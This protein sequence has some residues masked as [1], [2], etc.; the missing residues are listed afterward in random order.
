MATLV[1]AIQTS[2]QQLLFVVSDL[3]R[4]YIRRKMYHPAVEWFQWFAKLNILLDINGKHDLLTQLHHLE[5]WTLAYL[6][7]LS[8]L[9]SDKD[10]A[11]ATSCISVCKNLLQQM[12][13]II[14]QLPESGIDKA[15]ALDKAQF[16]EIIEMLSDRTNQKWRQ[17]E[18]INN[19]LQTKDKHM[20]ELLQNFEQVHV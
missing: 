19:S 13:D 17:F 11:N 5:Q 8:S 20:V 18:E 14:E 7:Y 6:S 9:E 15:M 10:K 1:T 3:C 16:E 4:E 12:S 2:N